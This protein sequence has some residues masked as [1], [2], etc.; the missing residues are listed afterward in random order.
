MIEVILLHIIQILKNNKGYNGYIKVNKFNT[1]DRRDK[2]FEWH[3]LPKL[4][5]K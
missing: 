2:F 5:T 3:K 1:L 4:I